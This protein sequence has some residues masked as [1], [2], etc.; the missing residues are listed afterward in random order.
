MSNEELVKQ[1]QQGINPGINM[2]QLYIQNDGLIRKIAKKYA[3]VDNMDDLMQEAYF[4]LYEAVKRYEDT[5]GVLFMSYASFWIKQAIVRYL[6]TNGR[7]IRIPS[8]VHNNILKYKKVLA[9]Y[10]MQLGRGP[11]DK[12]LCRHLNIGIK[13]L[14]TI[15]KEY[16]AS[17]VQSLDEVVPGTE[18]VLLGDS[19]PDQSSDLENDVINGMIEK[20]KQTDLWK[21]V[22][23]N[24]TPEENTVITARYINNMSLEAT[25]QSIGKTKERARCIEAKALRKLRLSRIR[26]EMEEKFEINYAM[27]YKG[28]LSR[29]NNT[30][31][32]IVEE[33]AI[34]NV[35]LDRISM[36]D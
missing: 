12:E 33:I 29:F 28:S 35:T 10:E 36:I 24:V 5:A 20:S 13:T 19:I 32:S 14:Q 6:E 11:T 2:E 18:D 15:K 21:I 4:G 8:L 1:I 26:R 22:K 7:S 31:S 16:Y 3:F 27:A 30:L 25:G 17:S 23:D 9:A 34:K